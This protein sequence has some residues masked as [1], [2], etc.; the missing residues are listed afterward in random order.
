MALKFFGY[1]PGYETLAFKPLGERFLFSPPP[2]FRKTY[3]VTSEQ[4]DALASKI[5]RAYTVDIRL[6]RVTFILALALYA[7]IVYLLISGFIGLGSMLLTLLALGYGLFLF[8]NLI[9]AAV[10]NSSIRP[11]IGEASISDVK[12]RRR[13]WKRNR[14]V[15]M[16]RTQFVFGVTLMPALGLA[17]LI[18]V[19]NIFDN[20]IDLL[21]EILTR[22]SFDSMLVAVAIV[23]FLGLA[24][25]AVQNIHL[26]L[27]RPRAVQNP[28]V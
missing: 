15:Y 27:S 28:G 3:V 26:R 10:L 20:P 7:M 6:R 25:N 5:R 12:F 14:V 19:I 13:D 1:W 24:W 22:P 18:I 23:S 11:I 17:G 9:F 4:R 16:P 21:A 8:L 2:F